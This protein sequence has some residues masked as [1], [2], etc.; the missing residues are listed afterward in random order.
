[1]DNV[2]DI[3]N[4]GNNLGVNDQLFLTSDDALAGLDFTNPADLAKA[5]EI[6]GLPAGRLTNSSGTVFTEI[7]VTNIDYSL[8]TSGNE[9]FIPGGT[10]S[11]G[12]PEIVVKPLNIFSDP[13]VESIQFFWNK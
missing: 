10:T 5:E 7:N 4:Y 8:P 3:T 13:A 2:E 6:L 9:F 1:L 11:G 12:A